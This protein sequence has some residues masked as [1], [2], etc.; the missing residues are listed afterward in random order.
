MMDRD[1]VVGAGMAAAAFAILSFLYG[2]WVVL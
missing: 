1:T 2:G